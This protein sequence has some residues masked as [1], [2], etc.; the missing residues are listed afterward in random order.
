MVKAVPLPLKHKAI[1]PLVIEMVEKT[2]EI[3]FSSGLE[4]VLD[5]CL[6]VMA[7]HSAIR[8]NQKLSD[9]EI[10]A[11]LHQLDGCDRSSNCPHGRP[12]WIQWRLKDLEKMF[13]RIV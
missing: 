3:D 12:T 11:L 8:A 10:N 7:C 5:R 9:R 13:K 4:A 2:A 1:K 6:E